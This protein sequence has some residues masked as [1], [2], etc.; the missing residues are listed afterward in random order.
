MD[1]VTDLLDGKRVLGAPNEIKEVKNAID[2]YNLLFELNPFDEKDLL[3][4]HKLMTADL[5]N[6]NGRYREGGVGIFDGKRCVHMAPPA[7]RVPTL[8]KNLLDWTERTETHPLISSCVFHYE[9]EFIH[10]FADG[11]GRIGRMWQTLLLMRWNQIFAWLPVESIVKENQ[12]VYYEVIAQCDN[13]GDST[14]FVE[15]MLNC[16]L[17]SLREFTKS[18]QKS[19]QKS[20]QKIVNA[21]RLNGEVT[22]R[23]LQEIVG[24]SESGVKKVIKQLRTHGVDEAIIMALFKEE[25]KLSR[26][27]VTEDYRILLPDYD[28][29]IKMAPLIKAVY[30]LFLRH[31][32]GIVFKDLVDY[33]EELK[34]IYNKITRYM[35]FWRVNRSID[36][37]V[38]PT[39]NAIN[40]K[41][42]R[43]REA[44]VA[45]LRED[46]AENYYI[47]GYRLSPKSIKLD[48]KL[49]EYRY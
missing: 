22:M 28:I 3:R 32:E 46:I 16:L 10:P 44:F 13:E 31:P 38:D 15:F 9:F 26:L 35:D 37:L 11:N 12:Q 45:Q 8:M 5:V 33:R 30:L 40:E 4:A 7:N 2:A 29:E 47:T 14:A 34:G 42:S 49:V 1:Q 41:C 23:E 17:I 27:Q 6:E 43:I 24:L 39:R 36:A 21:M 25:P 18:N 20:S 19:N 48:R